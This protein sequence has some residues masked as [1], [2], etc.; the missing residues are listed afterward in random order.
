LDRAELV[1]DRIV[2]LTPDK[3]LPYDMFMPGIAET[4]FQIQSFEKGNQILNRM[5]EIAEGRLNY[6]T[7]FRLSQKR[8][9][10]DE[11]SYYIRVLGNIMQ[12]SRQYN[13]LE[14]AMKAEEL[15]QTYRNDFM[16]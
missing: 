13:Q 7:G 12:I 4:Y 14:L 16:P 3:N 5:L 6:Y 9:I 15:L 10:Q 8:K 2:E 1:L 11:I